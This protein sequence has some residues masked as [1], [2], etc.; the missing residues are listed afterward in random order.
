MKSVTKMLHEKRKKGRK[1]KPKY[2][3]YNVH[4]LYMH[5]ITYAVHREHEPCRHTYTL[6]GRGW[7]ET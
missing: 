4:V 7:T 2:S 5:M 6:A 1:E 3:M